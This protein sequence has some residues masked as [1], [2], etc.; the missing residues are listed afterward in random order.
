MPQG[1]GVIRARIAPRRPGAALELLER[2]ALQR[3]SARVLLSRLPEEIGR[4]EAATLRGRLG[5]PED[6][7]RIETVTASGP[8]NALH[9]RVDCAHLTTLFVGFGARGVPAETVAG[10]VADEV[11]RY[12]DADVAVDPHLADQL[13][14]PLALGAGGCFST[15]APSGHTVT[16]AAVIGLFLPAVYEAREFAP[17]RWALAMRRAAGAAQS[18]VRR[19]PR[20][21]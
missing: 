4:R 3:C 17:G 20:T 21:K 5:L 19:A 1:G 10:R 15:L 9:V 8:G 14:L 2:G 18:A 7:C 12:L 11:Q 16:N 13:L 6:A